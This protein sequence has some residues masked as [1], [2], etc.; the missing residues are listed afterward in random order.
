VTYSIVARDPDSGQ[1]GVATQSQAF[2]VGASVS[3][4]M[5]G[6]GV[7][8]TQSM[9]EPMYG[10]LGLD[11]LRAGLT[12]SEALT[13]LRTVDPHPERRQVAMVDTCGRIDVYTGECCVAEAGHCVGQGCAALAN[14]M[15]SDD[16]WSAMVDAFE[17]AEGSLAFRLL[18]A[19]RAAEAQGGDLRGR[20]SAA[21]HVVQAE[22][23]GR[24]WRDHVVDLRVDDDPDPVGALARMM[25]YNARYHRVVEAFELALDDRAAE[26][27]DI[28]G[29]TLP[30]IEHEPELALWHAV[31]LSK[32]GRIDEARAIFA[33]LDTIAPR[34]VETARRFRAVQLVEP[35]L[36]D[37]I[38][39]PTT[40]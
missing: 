4:A 22:P 20:R 1:M 15:A 7:I 25:D 12:A 14:M 11:I 33:R 10:E 18:D 30:A 38:L 21:I 35:E 28:L 34:F 9:G 3:W 32:A 26:A 29:E 6:H 8:A 23:S 16:V 37:A 2:A 19:L 39:P 36:L 13:A 31:I 40:A 27:M 5:P 24:P 17:A